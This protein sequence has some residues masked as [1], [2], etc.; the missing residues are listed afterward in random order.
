MSTFAP[1]S[2]FDNVDKF[3]N[4]LGYQNLG[5]IV[6]LSLIPWDSTDDRDAFIEAITQEQPQGSAPKRKR[7]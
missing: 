2:I 5:V 3:A 1:G 7:I 4:S 6:K